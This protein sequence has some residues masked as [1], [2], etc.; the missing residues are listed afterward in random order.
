MLYYNPR[1]DRFS[2]RESGIHYTVMIRGLEHRLLL[3]LWGD[4]ERPLSHSEAAD[5]M[6]GG[7]DGPEYQDYA[8]ASAVARINQKIAPCRIKSVGKYLK[9]FY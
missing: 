6:W 5:I 4:P 9:L 3:A 1:A 8:I 7:E 2:L